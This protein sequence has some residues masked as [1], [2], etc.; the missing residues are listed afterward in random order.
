VV[1]EWDN[2]KGDGDAG[3]DWEEVGLCGGGARDPREDGG[4]LGVHVIFWGQWM[5]GVVQKQRVD[6]EKGVIVGTGKGRKKENG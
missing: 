4:G 1:V 3:E 6:E 2:E 5:D